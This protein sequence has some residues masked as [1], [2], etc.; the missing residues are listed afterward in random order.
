MWCEY[1]EGSLS[2]ELL[3]ISTAQAETYISKVNYL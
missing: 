2:I 1:S 3:K